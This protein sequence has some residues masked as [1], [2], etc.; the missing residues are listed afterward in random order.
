M[1]QMAITP[2]T[3]DGAC[4]KSCRFLTHDQVTSDKGWGSRVSPTRQLTAVILVLE[5]TPQ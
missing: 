1:L 3:C 4:W 2:I 5:D